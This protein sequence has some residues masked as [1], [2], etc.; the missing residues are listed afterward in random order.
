[1][2]FH[3][4]RGQTPAQPLASPAADTE[5]PRV[6][7]VCFS[8]NVNDFVHYS[9]AFK[10][11]PKFQI[12]IRRLSRPPAVQMPNSGYAP[13][14]VLPRHVSAPAAML[15][16]LDISETFG[17]PA[18]KTVLHFVNP[19]AREGADEPSDLTDPIS[20]RCRGVGFFAFLSA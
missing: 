10:T 13:T 1:M 14:C 16:M 15:T 18:L 2:P 11:G 8:A 9:F 17:H 12:S 20:L 4:A 19:F 3:R 6:R 7:S 5:I